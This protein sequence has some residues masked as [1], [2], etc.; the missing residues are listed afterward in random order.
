M[1]TA[2]PEPRLVECPALHVVGVG[3]TFTPASAPTGIPP[4]WSAFWA[5]H[6]EVQ[7][8]VPGRCYGFSTCP[9]RLD[10]SLPPQFEY[11]ACFGVTDTSDV[12]AGMVAR[13]APA[14]RYLVFTH[15]GHISGFQQTLAHIAEWIEASPYERAPTPDYELYDERFRAETMDGAFDVYVPVR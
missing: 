11:V 2:R 6:A 1:S 8:V 15:E 4:L 13:T 10:A 14:G 9:E 3:G 12:P 5:R 7:H